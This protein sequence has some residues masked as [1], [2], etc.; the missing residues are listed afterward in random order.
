[1]SLVRVLPI[2]RLPGLPDL[3]HHPVTVPLLLE[4]LDPRICMIGGDDEVIAPL[5]ELSVLG[6]PQLDRLEAATAVALAMKPCRRLD[7]VQLGAGLDPLV[8]LPEDLLVPRCPL[9][10][11]H[12]QDRTTART[13]TPRRG[14]AGAPLADGSWRHFALPDGL[15]LCL[16]A[17]VI[18]AYLR[19]AVIGIERPD[20]DR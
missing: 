9:G 12:A 11:V 13:G 16:R 2:K 6:G 14:R 5:K 18:D 17:P 1:V 20:R 15:D 10:E 8:D 19:V 4:A 3:L 7:P